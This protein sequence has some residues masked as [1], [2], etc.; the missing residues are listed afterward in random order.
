MSDSPD[1]DAAFG[2]VM[3]FVVCEDQ[4][5]PY[6]ADAFVAGWVAGTIDMLLPIVAPHGLTV[7]R[8]VVPQL[9]SQLDLIAMRHGYTLTT[10]PWD[11]HP[12]DWTFA[13]FTPTAAEPT[14]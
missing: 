10:E 2:L 5:G 7:E 13:T 12:D 6:P 3:P 4:G 11:E 1:Q 9:V 14:S 8:Y